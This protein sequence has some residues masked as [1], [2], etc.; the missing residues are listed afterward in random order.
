MYKYIVLL[1][2]VNVGGNNLL[3]M[4]ELSVLLQTNG[5]VDVSTY[6]QSGNIVLKSTSNP[7]SKIR[8]LVAEKFGFEPK[9]LAIRVAQFMQAVANNPFK[10]FEG[11]TVH[12]YF[13]ARAISLDKQKFA[14]FASASERIELI[15]N[16]FYLDA[17]N[18]IGRSKL[19]ASIE[20]CLGVP[21]TGRNLNTVNKLVDMLAGVS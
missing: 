7:V 11:K 17:P 2:G 15:D 5:F 10:S 16:V 6:I 12:F 14:K 3:P 4:K 21:A 18:G 9:G 8:T 13:C 19:V 20:S 1:R